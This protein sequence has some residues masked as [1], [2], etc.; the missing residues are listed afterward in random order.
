M[1]T[2]VVTDKGYHSNASLVL[3]LAHG[4]GT[5]RV[6]WTLRRDLWSPR[7]FLTRLYEDQKNISTLSPAFGDSDEY[8]QS[9]ASQKLNHRI[10]N[11]CP[12]C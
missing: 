8:R 4:K 2:E 12:G 5:P 7:S 9:R 10:G 11:Y 6:F 1:L 3:R